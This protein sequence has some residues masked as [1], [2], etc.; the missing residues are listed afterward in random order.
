MN[1]CTIALFGCALVAFSSAQ[2]MTS[3]MFQAMGIELPP[4]PPQMPQSLRDHLYPQQ[5]QRLRQQ[6]F[7]RLRAA[8]ASASLK[9]KANPYSFP[10]SATN[11]LP[12]KKEPLYSLANRIRQPGDANALSNKD[13]TPANP[14]S[15]SRTASSRNPAVRTAG[16]PTPQNMEMYRQ[17]RQWREQPKRIND[18]KNA[19]CK[20]PV[21]SAA[22]S[23]L[24]FGDCR[25]PSAR[26][27]CQVEMMT[28]MNVG[29]SAMCCPY[30]MNKLAMDTISYFNKMQH[31]ISE[32][33]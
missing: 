9:A 29:L 7:Q 21:D 17:L 15:V 32:V 22:A 3:L 14:Y 28:C 25:N 16:R 24:M 31:F 19:G 27:V 11:N 8:A 18:A 5:Q 12:D 2:D 10:Y 20:L 1:V 13:L 23:V 4:M 33:A 6:Q 30:G 26:F